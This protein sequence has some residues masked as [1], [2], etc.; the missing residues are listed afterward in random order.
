METANYTRFLSFWGRVSYMG[1][2]CVLDKKSMSM[3]K[4]L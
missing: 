1:V 3:Q 2:V 4:Y